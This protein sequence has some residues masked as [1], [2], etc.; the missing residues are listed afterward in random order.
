MKLLFLTFFALFSASIPIG[1]TITVDKESAQSALET[2]RDIRHNPGSYVKELNFEED[3]NNVSSVELIWNDTLA[4]V[5]EAKAFDLANR[6]YF[7]HVDPDGYGI[8]YFIAESG[9][10]LNPE[11]TVNKG[12]VNFE[13]LAAGPPTGRDAIK[14]LVKDSR[15]PN[16]GHRKHLLGLDEWNANTTDVGIGYVRCPSGCKYKTYVCVIIAKHDR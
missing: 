1:K 15:D 16:R 4:K 3:I 6:N 7:D 8:N 5:A 9:Y 10:S 2:L 14:Q 13:S 11:W 12:D